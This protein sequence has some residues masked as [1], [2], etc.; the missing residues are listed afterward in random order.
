MRRVALTFAKLTANLLPLVA[1]ICVLWLCGCAVVACGFIPPQ[2]VIL[3]LEGCPDSCALK[4][5]WREDE[6]EI[7]PE[8]N[9]HYV[10]TTPRMRFSKLRYWH[11]NVTVPNSYEE[12][13]PFLHV[14]KGGQEA[15]V[16]S[17][18]D[19]WNLPKDPNGTSVLRLCD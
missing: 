3:R 1:S 16:L 8:T 11:S 14:W 13:E 19:I 7:A 10:L 15:R 17:S 4:T 2:D 18:E 6:H 12:K 9:G 5:K